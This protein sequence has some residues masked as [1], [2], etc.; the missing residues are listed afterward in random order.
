[1][2]PNA[3]QIPPDAA[4]HV[5]DVLEFGGKAA[6]AL[7]AMWAFV[8][9]VVKPYS[10]WRSKRRADEIRAALKPELDAIARL[11]AREEET[12]KKLDLV[13]DRQTQVFDEIDLFMVV[14]ADNRERL[15]E[16]NGLLDEVFSSRD[17]RVHSARRQAADVA[18]AEL[19]GRVRMRRRRT[20]DLANLEVRKE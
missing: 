9:G 5:G 14:V 1:M 17:R 18:L 4:K 16:T 13:I 12:D 19:Q 10:A 2:T 8:I 6:V 20:D 3:P 7:G 11:I 15:D